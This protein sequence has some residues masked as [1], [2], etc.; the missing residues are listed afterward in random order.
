MS[1]TSG[2]GEREI[3]LA[4]VAPLGS[5]TAETLTAFE[6]AFVGRGYSVG[7]VRVS[8]L[9]DANVPGD[10]SW[11]DLPRIE[12]LMNKGD[13]WRTDL[14][15]DAVGA[16]TAA[17]AIAALRE[18]QTGSTSEHRPRF[19]TLVR[20]LKTPGEVRALR[21]IYGQRVLVVGVGASHDERLAGL[22]RTL[23]EEGWEGSQLTAKASALLERDEKD[24]SQRYGQR[25]SDA[26][27]LCDA[28]IAVRRQDD[29]KT[30]SD[31]VDLVLGEPWK[32]PSRD[33]QGMF[34]AWAAKF[35]SSAAGR[36]VGAA[37]VD[38]DGELLAVGC[39]DVP[40]PG[41]GQYWPGDADDRR[42]FQ[43]QEDANDAGKLGAARSLMSAL[44][45]HGWLSA[46]HAETPSAFLAEKALDDGG[47]L[48]VSEFD[49][50]I[51]YGR[52]VHAEM[53]ALMTAARTGRSVR[54]STLYTTTYPCHEC[55]RLI[56]G[57]GITRVCF[58]DPYPKSR[59]PVLF[60]EM[61]DDTG[62][63]GRVRV[64]PFQGVSP[65]LFAR[66][67]E[68]VNRTKDVGGRYAQ[69]ERKHLLT[70]DEELADS[71]PLQEEA[72]AALLDTQL[73]GGAP[74]PEQPAG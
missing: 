59:A 4:V 55:A 21:Q 73:A 49:D 9:I 13:R 30:V 22:K 16:Y 25:G 19:V 61:F 56:I 26:Y 66:V 72:A 52:I 35:R 62:L 45:E 2:R 7:H 69:W 29:S 8:E 46:E 63:P 74:E 58:V 51:E 65:R 38:S 53:A 54:G 34:H 37:L 42:D 43:L 12:R 31:F 44:K 17:T 57:A 32:T 11:K 67:Y 48:S 36:Q 15:D 64:D 24:E 6:E 14:E 5:P 60:H 33:E 68:M 18:L 1:D 41:G 27:R 70:T 40:K 39:N 28:F 71:I 23:L 10:P 50:L 3:V 47:P 20:S